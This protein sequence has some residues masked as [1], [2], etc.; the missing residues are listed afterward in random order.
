MMKIL[1]A[2]QNKTVS[3]YLTNALKKSGHKV[4]VADHF[5]SAWRAF[6][7]EDFGILLVNIVMPGVDGFT[8]AQ[9]ALQNNPDLQVIFLTGFSGVAMDAATVPFY[10][11]APLTTR[12]FH[13]KDIAARVHYLMGSARPAA[14]TPAAAKSDNVFYADFSRKEN[15]QQQ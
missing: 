8:L 11:T 5:L 3:D 1:V 10:A 13:L 4:T 6:S 14:H 2:E 15:A 9:K 12:P 7:K